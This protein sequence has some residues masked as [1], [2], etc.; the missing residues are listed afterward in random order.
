MVTG[1][2]TLLDRRSER[3]LLDRL[4]DAAR[5]GQSAVLV[6]RGEPGIGKTALLEYAAA[7]GGLRV[8][9]V[10]GVESEMELPF[11][12][13]QQLCAPLLD[14]M[15]RLPGPQRDAL[16][17]AFG[18]AAGN[19]PDRFMVGL[20]VL[21]LLSQAGRRQPLLC[22][23]DDV[24]WLDGASAQTIA[25]AA[26]RLQA[27]PVAMLFATRELSDE[28]A[29]LPDLLVRGLGSSDSQQLLD[30]AVGG[31]MD[32][33]VRAR[34]IAEARGN[35]LALLE[36][37][38]VWTPA[39]LTGGF[40]VA[41]APGLP[42]WL[43]RGFQRRFEAL[44]A[45]TQR[46]L[47]VAAADPTG[48]PVLVWNAA[49]ELGLGPGAA[50][51]AEAEQLVSFGSRV[52]FRHP[53]VRSAIYRAAP[54]AERRAV[55]Q[56]LAQATDPRDD[57]A[58]RA[59]HRAQ[60]A[61]GPDE[62]V[63]AE[64]EREAVRA[65]ACGGLA[66]AAAFLERSAALTLDPHRRAERA[67]AAAQARQQAGAFEVALRL[68]DAAEAGPLDGPQRARAA[69]L[70]GRIA[71]ALN[72]GSDAPPLL[73]AAA[74]QFEPLDPG[75]ARETYLEAV[76]AAL[77]AGRLA[78]DGGLLAAARAARA[79]PPP[80]GAPRPP[81]LLLDGFALLIT[82]GYPA[83]APSLK[84]A[85]HA[86]RGQD[87][88]AQEGLRW[89]WLA[90]HA[91]GL[92]WDYE[93]WDVLSARFVRLGRD[94]GA[95]TVLP[96]A[97]STRAGACL[98]AGEL[99][100]AASLGGEEAAVT[101]ATGSRIAPYAALGLA[102]FEGRESDA[103][104]LIDIGTN[105]VLHRGEGV[106]L[107]FIQWAAAVLHNGLGRYSAALE[108]AQQASE[109]T[110]AQRFTSWALAELIEAGARSG[111]RERAT[112]A[113]QQLA[114][115][116]QAS[117]TDW[118]LGVEACSRALLSDGQAAEDLYH[119]A[120]SRLGRTRL[121]VTLARAHLLYGEWLRRERR[122]IDAREQLR[123]AHQMFTDF[124]MD[125]FAG[126]ARVE[127]EATGER[128]RKRTAGTRT[129]LTP[130]ETQIARLVTDGATN[131]E[132]AARLFI[133]ASTVDYHLRKTFRKLG[134][135]SRSQLARHV[136]EL[137]GHPDR[138]VRVL[139]IGWRWPPPAAARRR[140][141]LPAVK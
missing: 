18:L 129:D 79:A 112:A 131:A 98:F 135:R 13:V 44:P 141:D 5:G 34:I 48:D 89:L 136:L 68:L 19:A 78:T 97:L 56:A 49:R 29:G 87:L 72:F 52:V 67:L 47:L 128:A 125:G 45:D 109:D 64:L 140:G 17:T 104:Q 25:F 23:V 107:T 81:D 69:L 66:A 94:A 33:R 59:W 92:L 124:G 2:R 120:V 50:A 10:A 71:F 57:P 39:Q 24:Q 74:R 38:R 118:A 119:E 9:S 54:M 3:E 88:S 65:Q 127:L 130:Q 132:I 100:V 133:S 102:A 103:V 36:L 99:T 73:L 77:L 63:A 86:F 62:D 7:D 114:Q 27:D 75:L 113:L 53:L 11:A 122:R 55:H 76:S 110:A 21:G 30:S 121:R 40:G 16:A 80:P 70:H 37:R 115:S 26:R 95:L 12:A 46:L 126:R 41:D 1:K 42:G 60:A 83:A 96:V 22:V 51:A 6:V 106:G 32:E 31:R 111:T 15:G 20:A 134:V 28:L 82:D 91:A 84:R 101:E 8:L 116:T 105:D 117:G 61:P 85:V 35:P 139:P 14:L 58:R 123:R 137:S 90:G 138:G 93:S 108:W 43:E 4:L